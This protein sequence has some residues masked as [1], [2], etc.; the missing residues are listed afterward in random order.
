[1][2]AP[3]M[4][5]LH[6]RLYE[7]EETKLWAH[8]FIDLNS[9]E[10]LTSRLDRPIA[11]LSRAERLSRLGHAIDTSIFDGPSYTLAPRTPYQASPTAALQ[12]IGALQ[13]SASINQV[14]W[15]QPE[16]SDNIARQIS[17][18]LEVLPAQPSIASISLVGNSYHG[19]VGHVLV[20][21]NLPTNPISLPIGDVYSAHTVDL[22]VI[23]PSS[24]FKPDQTT[25]SVVL[26]P[27]IQYLGFEAISFFPASPPATI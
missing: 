19:I 13:Y 9:G 25:I 20:S 2:L 26:Q 5:D 22:F 10:V 16:A 18:V 8:H 14:W 15:W 4:K 3:G 27:G 7:V 23:P 24:F 12:V 17:F 11:P 1:M 6:R 21:S